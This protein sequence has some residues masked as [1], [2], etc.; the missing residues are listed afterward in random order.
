M[1]NAVRLWILVTFLPISVEA[2]SL[3]TV[4]FNSPT[5]GVKQCNVQLSGEIKPGDNDALLTYLKEW[6]NTDTQFFGNILILDSPGGDV[7]EAIKIA[8]TVRKALLSTWTIALFTAP[9]GRPSH[10]TYTCASACFLIWASGPEK[11]FGQFKDY[12]RSG[13]G[14][15]R[16][17]FAP[18]GYDRTDTG[19]VASDQQT[20][21]AVAREFLRREGVPDELI[22]E[23]MQRSS[24]EVLWLSVDDAYKIP[25]R[26]PWYE[27]WLIAR[28]DFD[29]ALDEMDFVKASPELRA[30]LFAMKNRCSIETGKAAA[31]FRRSLQH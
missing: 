5:E 16:P 11:L 18:S 28:C 24:R 7:R 9:G 17:Y 27:E 1:R 21:M 22:V 25:S 29:P 23:M 20:L 4:C 6:R 3:S 15:H 10:A 12:R 13:L 8:G 31:A 2:A 30:K 19:Q 14:L 26:A